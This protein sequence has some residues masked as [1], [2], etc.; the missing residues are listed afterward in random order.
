MSSQI[1]KKDIDKEIIINFLESYSQ[2]NEQFFIFS[3]I[4]FRQ[5][6]YHNAI[7]PLCDKIRDCYHKSKLYY[8][9][10]KL[11]YSKFIT[12]LRQICKAVNLSYTSRIIYINSSYNIVYYISKE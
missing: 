2:Q 5:A 1:F 7:V 12:V 9:E 3:K 10:R 4:N 6:E 11:N 8:I